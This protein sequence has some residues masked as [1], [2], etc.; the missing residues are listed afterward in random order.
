MAS[1][2]F[3]LKFENMELMVIVKSKIQ[4]TLVSTIVVGVNGLGLTLCVSVKPCKFIV[5][6][7]KQ[8]K[9]KCKKP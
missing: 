7:V 1:I 6:H 3:F 4:A 2:S 5:C 8:Y 9:H